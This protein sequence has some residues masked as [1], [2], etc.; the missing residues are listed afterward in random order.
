MSASTQEPLRV[1]Y[2]RIQ[3]DPTTNTPEGIT[4]FGSRIENI[5]LSEAAVPASPLVQSGRVYVDIA[6]SVSTGFAIANPNN[7]ENL[8]SFYFTNAAGVDFGYGSFTLKPNGQHASFLHEYPFHGPTSLQGTFT[9]TSSLPASVIALRG[10]IN[11]RGEFLMTT[12][13]VPRM[14]TKYADTL[15]FPHFA[16]GGGWS[17]QL[18]LT[19]PTNQT[20]L[21]TGQ[22]FTAG[23][24]SESAQPLSLSLNG[25]SPTSSFSY[26]IPPHGALRLS[27]GNASTNLNAGWV[28]IVPTGLVAPSGSAIFSF[29]RDGI[30]VAEASVPALPLGFAFRSYVETSGMFGQVGSMQSG[31]AVANPSSEPIRIDFELRRLD[32]ASAGSTSVTVPAGGQVAKFINELFPN[33]PAPFQGILQLRSFSAVAVTGLRGRYNERGDFL[34]TSIP[35]ADEAAPPINAEMVFPHIVSGGGFSTQVVIFKNSPG[36]ATGRLRFL[37]QDGAVLRGSTIVTAQTQ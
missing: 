14:E 35:P 17:T 29:R 33:L 7:A 23:S 37:S 26:S 1:G 25:Q 15:V 27:T 20:L 32:G 21:G 12:L 36:V 24:A 28:K 22:L 31:L 4:I 3:V 13:P 5:L 19:N 30:T 2:S 11:E 18:I 9:F 8:I 34:I 16:D 10:L 6:G